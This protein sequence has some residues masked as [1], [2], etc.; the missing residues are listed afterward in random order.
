[1]KKLITLIIWLLSLQLSAQN[2]E[3]TILPNS[4]K[5]QNDSLYFRYR[6]ENKSDTAFIFYDAGMVDVATS[7][8][9][10]DSKIDFDVLPTHTKANTAGLS[11]FI[12]DEN[13][14]FRPRTFIGLRHI[15]IPI[16]RT[17]EDNINY[18][19]SEYT[20]EPI[21]RS[22]EDSI[23]FIYSG[24]Y[25]VLNSGEFVEHERRLDISKRDMGEKLEKGTYKFR[26]KYGFFSDYYRVEYYA[27]T[28]QTDASLKGS[29]LFEGEIWSDFYLFEYP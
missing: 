23:Y 11:C 7:E 24:K 12:Y 22:Y 10:I 25:I 15:F 1:M 16:I 26:L 5:V 4:V 6:I 8:K 29:F 28:R 18:F 13:G 17:Y 9:Q 14:R 20:P 19:Y 21:V 27:R 3:L 2:V